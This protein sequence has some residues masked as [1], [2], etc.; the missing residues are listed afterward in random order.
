LAWHRLHLS[1]RPPIGVGGTARVSAASAPANLIPAKFRVNPTIPSGIVTFLFT[2][3]HGS[4]QLWEA[5]PELM[6][7]TLARRDSLLR[8]GSANGRAK[9]K[10]RLCSARMCCGERCRC[11][12]ASACNALT[13][14]QTL[15]P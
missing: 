11:P 15:M 12:I 14:E 4:A 3:I 5:H 1:Q 9:K 8:E 2:D 13:R 7:V 10:R 6:W